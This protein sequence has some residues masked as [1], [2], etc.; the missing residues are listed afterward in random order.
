MLNKKS[1]ENRLRILRIFG[2]RNRKQQ[3]DGEI[4]IT[5]TFITCTLHQILKYSNQGE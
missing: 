4:Y 2:Y 3:G 1:K 5:I